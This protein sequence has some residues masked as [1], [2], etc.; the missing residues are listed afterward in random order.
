MRDRRRSIHIVERQRLAGRPVLDA[1]AR[2]ARDLAPALRA[3]AE[4]TQEDYSLHK[5]VIAL[6]A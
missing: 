5:R 3:V 2:H 4:R 6:A 1:L